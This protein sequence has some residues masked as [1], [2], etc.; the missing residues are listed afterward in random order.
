MSETQKACTEHT[1]THTHTGTDE[2]SP[3]QV[4]RLA[5]HREADKTRG[6]KC[7]R[8][9]LLMLKAAEARHYFFNVF[10][11]LIVQRLPTDAH[12]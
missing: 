10:S 4:L 7:L 11:H 9:M 3:L 12:R 2:H 5:R 8:L 1:L 6:V